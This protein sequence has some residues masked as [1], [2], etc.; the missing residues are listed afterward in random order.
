[1]TTGITC[2]D[3]SPSLARKRLT[4]HYMPGALLMLCGL[5]QSSSQFYR[6]KLAIYSPRAKSGIS[7]VFVSEALLEHSDANLFLYCLWQLLGWEG[8]ME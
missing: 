3:A 7:A 4:T 5:L 1:M 2:T 8:K 6:Q